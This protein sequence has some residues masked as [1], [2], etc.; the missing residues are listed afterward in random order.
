MR[1]LFAAAVVVAVVFAWSGS[2][3]AQRLGQDILWDC[4]DV[5][6]NATVEQLAVFVRCMAYLEGA[7]D[8]LTMVMAFTAPGRYCPPARGMS[9]DQIRRIVQKWIR[10]H[11]EEMSE[12]ARG[13]VFTALMKTFP[14][15]RQKPL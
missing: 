10:D 15:S 2:A 7:N 11:P 5:P 3:S 4:S 8:M 14:C 12:S 1:S 9:N 6:P 13:V